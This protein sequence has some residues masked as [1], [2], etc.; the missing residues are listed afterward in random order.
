MSLV[1]RLCALV[2]VA[3]L[4]ALA[5]QVHHALELRREGEQRLR[6]EALRLSQF[7]AGEMD[8]IL[9]SARVLLVALAEQRSVREMDAAAC[10]A[11]LGRLNVRFPGLREVAA[12]DRDGRVF[13]AAAPLPEEVRAADQA[14]FRA[15]MASGEFTVG[16]SAA[17]RP[18]GTRSLPVALAFDDAGGKPAGV[19]ALGLGLDWLGEHFKA[20]AWPPGSSV[21][22]IDRAG[23]IL[24]RWPNPELAGGQIPD[25][26]RWMLT[27][28]RPGTTEGTGPDGVVRVGGYV[29]PAAGDG[30][31]VSVALSKDAALAD[32]DAVLRRNLL[33]IAA[34][35]ALALLAAAVGGRWLVRH[36]VDRLLAVATRW[37]G[38]DYG[39]RAGLGDR[40]SELGRLGDA[41]DAMAAAVEE[42]EAAL[43]A[44]E[45][46]FRLL[47]DTVPD[48]VW[49]AAPDGAITYAN[50]RWFE[51]CGIAPQANARGWP[52]LVLHPDDRER[53]LALWTRSLRD[54]APYEIEVRNR[55]H[56]GAYRWF[57]TRA[58]PVRDG[59]GRVVAW[60]G[61]TTDI[62]DRKRGEEERELL[63]RELRH[64]IKNVFALVHGLAAQ[65][66]RHGASPAEFG[67]A[68]L[69]RLDTLARVSTLLRPDDRETADLRAVAEAAL[70]P[71]RA[72]GGL[73]IDGPAVELPPTVARNLGL[74]LHE[75]ATNATKYGALSD[76]D[77][78]VRLA[79]SVEG[80]PGGRLLV[81]D[82]AER[83]G[84]EVAPPSRRG[85]GCTLIERTVAHGLGGKVLLEFPPA[86][87]R[88][89]I[90]LPLHPA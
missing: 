5:I 3:V 66:L 53:C 82:W 40:G 27:A 29:P 76:G 9:E 61:A 60:F 2:L 51:Y 44:S 22:I 15:A 10:S 20:K 65:S 1:A 18:G 33:L 90:E 24:V 46:R 39:A 23:T 87:A 59:D 35:L 19:V 81:L 72:A 62:D 75:L 78:S 7:A 34:A 63:L 88:C 32:L 79:W 36:P 89:R 58:V 70:E 50:E 14:H 42:R 56:D 77:G 57:L 67:P 85:F 80:G 71:Y 38:G 12:L 26:F 55:R 13:C 17:G 74:V 84:P 49:T 6:Q 45:E 47:A 43:R 25:A 52:E 64:R 41:F 21:S 8:R 37:A 83:G 4:P 86:G 30:L 31:L 73:R 48:I 11:Y 28:A 16:E 54:G 69:G 68:F